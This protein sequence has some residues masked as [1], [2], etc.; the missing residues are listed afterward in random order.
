[1]LADLERSHLTSDPL[2]YSRVDLD[3]DLELAGTYST[4]EDEPSWSRA[5]TEE[6]MNE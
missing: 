2:H 4:P 1:M 5:C 6:W 3:V